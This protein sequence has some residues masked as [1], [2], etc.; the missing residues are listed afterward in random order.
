V[1]CATVVNA[2]GL[3]AQAVARALDG[4]DAATI[5]R[6]H[7]A[8]G[9]YFTLRGPSPF[10]RLIYPVASAGGLGVHLTLDLAGRARF[11][12]DVTWIDAAAGAF[13]YA[14]DDR[15]APAFYAAVRRYW[16]A[17]PDGALDPGYTG[18]RPKLAPAGAPEADF[19]IQGPATHGVPGLVNLY[20]IDSPGLTACLAIAD[21]AVAALTG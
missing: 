17:L 14:F 10:G 18:I 6:A 3:R 16:P 8:K 9:H 7:W 4:L 2:A 21:A 13:D 19:V 15:R 5:P 1:G 20:G 11:G 12:P